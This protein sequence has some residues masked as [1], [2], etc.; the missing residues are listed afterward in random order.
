MTI[1]H[2]D[3]DDY[4]IGRIE[5]AFSDLPWNFDSDDPYPSCLK[6]LL[7]RRWIHLYELLELEEELEK[8]VT[9]SIRSC[10]LEDVIM[11]DHLD[12]AE[13]AIECLRYVK[14]T[15]DRFSFKTRRKQNDAR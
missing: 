4:S 11:E 7:K 9:R 8:I 6:K 2:Y 10:L 3:F 12:D 1:V 15:F 14:K 5:M 13:C